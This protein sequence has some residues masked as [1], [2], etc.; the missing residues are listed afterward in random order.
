[1]KNA[2]QSDGVRQRER[3]KKAEYRLDTV[4]QMPVAAAPSIQFRRIPRCCRIEF[5]ASSSVAGAVRA[6]A[7]N[8]CHSFVWAS[9]MTDRKLFED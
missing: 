9:L 7:T 1:M 8:G 3:P 2:R 4:Q 6:S 5:H